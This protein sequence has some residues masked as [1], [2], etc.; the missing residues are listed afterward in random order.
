MVSA[1]NYA[2]NESHYLIYERG[3]SL[4]EANRLESKLIRKYK[5]VMDGGTLWNLSLGGQGR[6]GR[7]RYPG[8]FSHTDESRAMSLEELHYFNL[9]LNSL[10]SRQRQPSKT[11]VQADA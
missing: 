6:S 11:L 7:I 10:E 2:G 5:R 3:L 4:V 1:K 9:E 8:G